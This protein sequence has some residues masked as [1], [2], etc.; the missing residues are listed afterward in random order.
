[1]DDLLVALFLYVS[2][3]KMSWAPETTYYKDAI[4][5]FAGKQYIAV[6]EGENGIPWNVLPDRSP[7]YWMPV[8]EDGVVEPDTGSTPSKKT[9]KIV[10]AEFTLVLKNVLSV[11]VLEE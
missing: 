6:F 5:R 8:L 4:V 9:I 7:E 2:M 11:E 3:T 1:M 10:H